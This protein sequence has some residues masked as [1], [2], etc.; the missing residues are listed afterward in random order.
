MVG[1]I[2]YNSGRGPPKDYAIKVS[3]QL[4]KQFQTERFQNIFPIG[5]YVNIMSTDGRCLGLPVGSSDTS[6]KG[7]HLR[8]IST[9]SGPN[10]LS[11]LREKIF[12]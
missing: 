2:G 11:N 7:A 5:S 8:T 1:V 6:L 3:T 10:W 4:A 12:F 9:K